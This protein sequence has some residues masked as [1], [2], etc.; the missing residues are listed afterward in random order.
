MDND[1]VVLMGI[2]DW[3]YEI[4][5]GVQYK[6]VHSKVKSVERDFKEKRRKRKKE[7]KKKEKEDKK[8]KKES[9][10]DRE[11]KNQKKIGPYTI[12]DRYKKEDRIGE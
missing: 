10:N 2:P 11:E 5:P 8:E 7:R 4:R 3:L 12:E 9:R 1:D 6:Q